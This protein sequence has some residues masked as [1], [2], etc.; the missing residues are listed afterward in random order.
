MRGTLRRK[1][2]FENREAM[3]QNYRN[4]KVFIDFSDQVLRDYVDGLAIDLEDGGVG[5]RYSPE[6]E[7]RIYETG[8]RADW[9]IWRGRERVKPPTLI[10]RGEDTYTLRDGLIQSLVGKMPHGEFA[11]VMGTG[12]LLP[13]E[14]PEGTAGVALGFLRRKKV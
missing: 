14:D 7:A 13:L 8:G 4:K 3:F 11:T 2:W 10:I 1:T 6:W 5:L 9:V 12:H